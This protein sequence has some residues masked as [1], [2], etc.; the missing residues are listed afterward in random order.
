MSQ[1]L[2]KTERDLGIMVSLEPRKQH[3]PLRYLKID[4]GLFNGQG[5]TA[6]GDFDSH[7]DFIARAG[8]KPYP[9][10]KNIQLSFAASYLN[11]GCFKAPVLFIQ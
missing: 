11:G 9:V 4:A 10:T 1:I 7:K 3:Y 8:L 2:M 6:P 5:L